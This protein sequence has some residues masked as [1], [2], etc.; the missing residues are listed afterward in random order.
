MRAL[1]LLAAVAGIVPA[2]AV[3]EEWFTKRGV[4]VEIAR[5][6]P[7]PPWVRGTAEIAASPDRIAQIVTDFGRYREIFAPALKSA[8]VLEGDRNR[9]RL[10]LVWPYP[11]PLRNRDA[12]VEY[13]KEEMPGGGLRV[14]WRD[15]V[16]PSDPREGVRIARVLGETRIEPLEENRSRVT[17]AFLGDLGGKFP[18]SAEEKAWRAEPVE[19]V[20]ALRRAL[21]LPDPVS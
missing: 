16:R 6:S 15:A 13:A 8:R 21:G 1:A 12:V 20:R 14:F 11:F 3:F 4:R 10:H 7:G 17:Y 9:A 18:R 19:Y 2:E 5:R